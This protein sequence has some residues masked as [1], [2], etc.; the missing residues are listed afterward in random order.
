MSF[1]HV[2]DYINV[3]H[4]SSPFIVRAIAT[5]KLQWSFVT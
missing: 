2:G 4:K 1:F 3:Y 5:A